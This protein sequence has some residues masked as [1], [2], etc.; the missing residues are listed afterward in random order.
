MYRVT[1][2][3]ESG[4]H[5]GLGGVAASVLVWHHSNSLE[6]DTAIS[7]LP[8]DLWQRWLLVT[9]VS[10]KRSMSFAEQSAADHSGT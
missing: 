6:V 1:V 9:S 4:V 3:L 8:W 5:I 10:K 2:A 7:P